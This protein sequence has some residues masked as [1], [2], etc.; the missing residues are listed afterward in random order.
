M[1]NTINYS[2]IIFVFL[3][4]VTTTIFAADNQNFKEEVNIL[5]KPI[6]GWSIY[7]ESMIPSP[8]SNHVVAVARTAK[9]FCVIYDVKMQ[10]AYDQMGERY[11]GIQL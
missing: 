1:K 7:P 6:A 10:P 4:M 9:K 5:I 8:D 2:A 11:S 3:F